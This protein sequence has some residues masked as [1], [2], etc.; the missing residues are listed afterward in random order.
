M[1]VI[2]LLQKNKLEVLSQKRQQTKLL[3]LVQDLISQ[4]IK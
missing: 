4:I 2:N 1:K 3:K